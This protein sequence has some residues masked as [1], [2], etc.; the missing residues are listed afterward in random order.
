MDIS[1]VRKAILGSVIDFCDVIFVFV[2][3]VVFDFIFISDF[4]FNTHTN[5]LFILLPY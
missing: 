1:P 4:V 5:L 2:F 3:D